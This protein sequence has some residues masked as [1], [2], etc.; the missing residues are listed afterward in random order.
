MAG[1]EMKHKHAEVLM[2]IA[3]GKDVEFYCA[4]QWVTATIQHSIYNPL[5]HD[6]FE[7]RIKQE[8]VIED[9]YFYLN[10][11]GRESRYI[12]FI[13]NS[14]A[15]WDLKITYQDGKAINAVLSS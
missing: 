14:L 10:N 13:P 7:W 8:Q 9:K 3:E 12:E 11:Q 4:D 5:T 1:S 2:A 6:H 15:Q